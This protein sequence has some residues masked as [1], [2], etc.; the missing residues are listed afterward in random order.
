M[1]ADTPVF[2]VH[3]ELSRR[4][5][6]WAP[7]AAAPRSTG[8]A[9]R[10]G[11]GTVPAE[12]SS[13]R[14]DAWCRRDTSGLAVRLRG[15]R[16]SQVLPTPHSPSPVIAADTQSVFGSVALLGCGGA[17]SSAPSSLFRGV[18]LCRRQLAAAAPLKVVCTR[19]PCTP[20][21][22]SAAVAGANPCARHKSSGVEPVHQRVRAVHH[23]REP[24]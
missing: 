2:G 21:S 22:S 23:R 6:R 17:A 4:A 8:Y 13:G 20:T 5:P 14:F 7:P 10:S 12:A 1:H 16:R 18:L 19:R 24:R 9:R 3:L 15:A 11:G